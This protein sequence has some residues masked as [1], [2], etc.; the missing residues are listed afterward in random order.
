MNRRKFIKSAAISGVTSLATMAPTTAKAVGIFDPLNV[1]PSDYQKLVPEVFWTTKPA[2]HVP[3]LIIGSGFGGSIAAYRLSQA[4]I[5]AAV[6]ERGSHWPTDNKREIHPHD[7]TPDG[8]SYWQRTQ[9]TPLNGLNYKIDKFNGML[10]MTDYEN[11]SVWRGACVGGG[12]KVFTGVMIEPQQQYFNAIFGNTVD[13]KE[14]HEKYYPRVR[15]MLNLT[16]LPLSLYNSAPF[17]HSQIWD[18]QAKKAGYQTSSVDSLWNWNIIDQEIKLHSRPSAINGESN[19]G[20]SNGAKFDMTQNYLR[21][22][23][24]SGHVSV[25]P[26]MRVKDIG[27]DKDV[28]IGSQSGKYLVLVEQIDPYGNVLDTFLMSCDKLILSAGSIGT[29]ELLVK[30][31]AKGYLNKLNEHIGQGWGTN[32]DASALRSG[33]PIRG[34]T[35]AAPCASK[36]ETVASNG[37]PITL[38]NWYAVSV[39][40]NLGL[41]ASLSMVYDEFNRGHFIYDAATDTAK[42]N[43]AKEGNKGVE[44]ATREINNRI[45][46]ASGTV[47]GLGAISP[48]VN[49]K[50]TAHPLGGAVLGKAT[51]A[52]GR[53]VGYSGL[54]VMDGAMVNGST[55]AV[56]PSLTISALAE[57][58][59]EK[60]ISEDFV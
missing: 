43:W 28:G 10:D 23:Y 38:E 26:N 3:V 44:E 12:S 24:Q 31:K 11:I 1:I 51:D 54:Y 34:L 8:R 47:P 2:S 25:H 53:L 29:T 4:G 18:E 46:N 40:G 49:A 39:P 50:F 37:M 9:A 60:I 13:Y 15:T 5:K 16:P 36:L 52:Y 35:Q 7:F 27:Y 6:L 32:G 45:A 17:G 22:A 20:N 48:D 57:R 55:G 58:N 33:G 42:L 56:N 59:I 41:N 30:A 21:Y 14:M 19:H